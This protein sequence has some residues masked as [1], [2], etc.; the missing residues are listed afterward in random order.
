LY[1]KSRDLEYQRKYRK[2][3]KGKAARKRAELNH[4]YGITEIPVSECQ[5]CGVGDKP[6]TVDH[7]HRTGVI[8]GFLCQKCNL[9][10]G[11]FR[12]SAQNLVAAL[13][14]LLGIDE[15]I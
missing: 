8:R 6:L 12:D 2:T 5:I 10:L 14:Y 13:Y 15:E 7:D 9:G 4:R 11:Q 1:I 3:K